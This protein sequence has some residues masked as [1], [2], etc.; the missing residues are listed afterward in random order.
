MTNPALKVDVTKSAA[1][2]DLRNIWETGH[3]EELDYW[4]SM[5]DGKV[6]QSAYLAFRL[7]PHTLLQER[8]ID[9]LPESSRADPQILDVGAG[10]LSPVGKTLN[11]KPL[12]L[13][14]VDAL[15]DLYNKMLDKR[16]IIPAYRTLWAETERLTER[17]RPNSM[18]L[19]INCN[20]LDHSYDPIEGINQ[21][22]AVV[23]PGHCLLIEGYTNEGN[24]ADYFGLHQWNMDVQDSRFVI[25]RPDYRIDVLDHFKDQIQS[26]KLLV[27]HPWG[28][29]WFGVVMT[30]K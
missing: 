11:G 20:S 4:Q 17:V 23:K 26:H 2:K 12:R 5:L 13:I 24:H 8:Y 14:P 18:D 19:V 29:R 30:K 3:Q 6:E 28:E 22:L 9:A 27:P 10:P 21:M 16:G 7:N 25:W 1:P 15:A